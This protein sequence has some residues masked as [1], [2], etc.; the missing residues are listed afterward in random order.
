MLRTK[1][2]SFVLFVALML[3]IGSNKIN[4]KENIAPWVYEYKSICCREHP[5]VGRCLPGIDDNP[6]ND[7]KC[8]KFC[9]E[10]CER[11]GFCKLFGKKHV[12]HCYCSGK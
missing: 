8:W 2:V 4:G 12:C 5:D 1:V 11:G 7:G 9:V 3:C 6:D 10:G